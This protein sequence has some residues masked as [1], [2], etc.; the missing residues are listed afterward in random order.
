MF[1]ISTFAG[2]PYYSIILTVT[3]VT[4]ISEWLQAVV[5]ARG[6][7]DVAHTVLA[8]AMAAGLALLVLLCTIFYAPNKFVLFTNLM[9]S[10]LIA[11]FFLSTRYP[12]RPY[13]W[14]LQFTG[15]IIL[16]LQMFMVV[17][18]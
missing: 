1:V 4:I 11:S 17:L 15:Q 14:K 16:Y 5:P 3:V 2:R 9:L 8:T 6:K 18:L 7:T 12:P 10:T 13:L